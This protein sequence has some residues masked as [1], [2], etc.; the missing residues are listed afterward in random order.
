MISLHVS[1][2][3][4]FKKQASLLFIGAYYRKQNQMVNDFLPDTSSLNRMP[5]HYRF[6]YTCT[7]QSCGIYFPLTQHLKNKTNET[8]K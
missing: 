6:C 7:K 1:P 4:E 3:L 2:Y 5:V 8:K